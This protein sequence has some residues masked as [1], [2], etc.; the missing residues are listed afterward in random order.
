MLTVVVVWLGFFGF[1]A[2]QNCW[3]YPPSWNKILIYLA[4]VLKGIPQD[5]SKFIFNIL[6]RIIVWA[7]HFLACIHICSSTICTPFF[8]CKYFIIAIVIVICCITLLFVTLWS[9]SY[10]YKGYYIATVTRDTIKH[11]KRFSIISNEMPVLLLILCWCYFSCLKMHSDKF[12]DAFMSKC[13][14]K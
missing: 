5:F 6:F 1:D 10:N 14:L 7:L 4:V 12:F 2:S 8:L 9:D 13:F 3:V 11:L